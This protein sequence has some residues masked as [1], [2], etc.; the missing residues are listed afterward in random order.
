M[1]ANSWSADLLC[2]T[3]FCRGYSI[4]R[5]EHTDKMRQVIEPHCKAYFWHLF[6]GGF[7]QFAGCFQPVLCDKLRKG[8][9]LVA[10]EESISSGL[11]ATIRYVITPALFTDSG[12]YSQ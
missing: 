11:K 3:E 4:G 9:T 8:H 7:K 2:L 6:L 12:L 10:F 5:S 1:T